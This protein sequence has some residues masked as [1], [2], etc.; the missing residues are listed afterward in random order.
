M[1]GLR[2][3]SLK[4]RCTFTVDYRTSLK[5]RQKI[6]NKNKNRRIAEI[7]MKILEYAKG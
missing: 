2:D 5:R 6:K 4:L 1:S 7:K 3:S